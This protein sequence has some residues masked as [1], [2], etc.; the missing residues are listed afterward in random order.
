MF[1]IWSLKEIGIGKGQACLLLWTPF[2]EWHLCHFLLLWASGSFSW[3]P[4]LLKDSIQQVLIRTSSLSEFSAVVNLILGDDFLNA[5]KST[6]PNVPLCQHHT[7]AFKQITTATKQQQKAKAF[8]S[9][10]CLW[11]RAFSFPKMPPTNLWSLHAPGP[12]SSQIGLYSP[13]PRPLGLFYAS[14]SF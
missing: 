1:L 10:L 14:Q 7:Y 9:L 11:N 12:W 5:T 4:W 13:S 2:L 8:T 6:F 3:S